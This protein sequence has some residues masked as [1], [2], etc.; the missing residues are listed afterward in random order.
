MGRKHSTLKPE[1]QS[2]VQAHLGIFCQ[3]AKRSLANRLDRQAYA[4]RR[5][6][7]DLPHAIFSHQTPLF[8]PLVGAARP[9]MDAKVTNLRRAVE[10]LDGLVLDPGEALSFWRCLG[11]PRAVRGFV[12][13]FALQDGKVLPA[14]GGGL[15]QASNLLFWMAVHSPLTIQERWRH[16]YDVFPDVGRTQPFGSGAS[17]VFNHRDLRLLNASA[18]RYQIRLWLSPTQLHGALN[19]D[20]P[21]P[22]PIRVEESDHAITRQ[23]WGGYTRHNK[24]WRVQGDRRTLLVKNN[25]LLVY[26]PPE[27]AATS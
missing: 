25:A 13:G 8:R 7:Q 9:L 17:V 11:A 19:A 21:L 3:R 16:S 2:A 1:R 6:L 4:R 12:E 27:S 23:E 26:E 22:E 14:M 15:C 18:Y 20:A 24:I 5:E 10:A